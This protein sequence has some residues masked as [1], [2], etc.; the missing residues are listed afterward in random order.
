MN[1]VRIAQ[2]TAQPAV[3]SS[4]STGQLS[5]KSQVGGN[6]LPEKV[7]EKDTSSVN[8]TQ[9]LSAKALASEVEIVNK[10]VQNIQRDLQFS[11]DEDLDRTVIKVV[12]GDT[13]ELIRQI[14][15]DIFLELARRLKED[16]EM[17]LLNALG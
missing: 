7:P 6:A 15:D 4:S 3:V 8:Q 10:H 9:Q 16:G 1:E 14:P 2:T 5:A 12:D 17:N 11:V 13:G